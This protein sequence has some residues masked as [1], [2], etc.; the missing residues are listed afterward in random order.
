MSS[1]TST[2]S[3]AS[4]SGAG[5]SSSTTGN[6]KS[7]KPKVIVRAWKPIALR[8]YKGTSDKCSICFE[9]TYHRCIECGA[10]PDRECGLAF[11]ACG[12]IYHKCCIENW[13][14]KRSTCPLD[15]AEWELLNYELNHC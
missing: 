7:G 3:S 11:G 6:S 2:K 1:T 10:E 5:K 14:I 9:Y 12:H 8:T 4:K 15:N 13:T